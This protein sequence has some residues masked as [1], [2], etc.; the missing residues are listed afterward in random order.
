MELSELLKVTGKIDSNS[1]LGKTIAATIIGSYHE[2][3]SDLQ[4]LEGA[5]KALERVYDELAIVTEAF[6]EEARRAAIDED[7]QRR[8][9]GVDPTDPRI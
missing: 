5:H 7:W 3:D 2:D 1:L 4:Q 6:E 9:P 8:N